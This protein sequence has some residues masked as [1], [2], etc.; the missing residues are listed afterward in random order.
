MWVLLGGAGLP[1]AKV[2]KVRVAPSMGG[3]GH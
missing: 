3:R 2:S 1:D